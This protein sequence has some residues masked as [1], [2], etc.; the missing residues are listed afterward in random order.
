VTRG[1]YAA[2]A[3]GRLRALESEALLQANARIKEL[4]RA[5]GAIRHEC[6]VL[7]RDVHSHAMDAAA[8]ISEGEKN[9]LRDQIAELKRHDSQER[10]RYA[11]LA[12]E[13]VHRNEFHRPSP[14]KL[15]GE[16]Y[17]TESRAVIEDVTVEQMKASWDLWIAIHWEIAALFLPDYDE[18]EKFFILVEGHG[19]RV[20]GD[21]GWSS[22]EA[23]RNLR[24]GKIRDAVMKREY[25]RRD[26]FE[27]IWKARQ[28][29]HVEPIDTGVDIPADPED[30]KE[31]LIEKMKKER[32]P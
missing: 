12:W 8:K 11:V 14:A 22:R 18:M 23:T 21:V 15:W 9:D 3:E 20:A 28:G 6:D 25:R 13:I 16:A 10:I 30:V 1:K 5:L 7:R 24:V 29:G 4:E 31:N 32:R 19:W 2:K 27:R 26:Y 17:G